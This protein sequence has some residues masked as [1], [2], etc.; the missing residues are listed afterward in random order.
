MEM[1]RKDETI[2]ALRQ[3]LQTARFQASQ[4]DQNGFID[5]VGNS[6]VARLQQSGDCGCAS[7]CC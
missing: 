4:R 5:A 1:A 6:I 2:A 7:R 3:D